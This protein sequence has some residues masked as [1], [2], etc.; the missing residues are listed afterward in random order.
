MAKKKASAAKGLVADIKCGAIHKFSDDAHGGIKFE[1]ADLPCV[2]TI[3]DVPVED[4][5]NV[6]AEFLSK[7]LTYSSRQ[8]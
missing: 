5:D 1:T 7:S 4:I 6:Y 3:K 8:R 2:I